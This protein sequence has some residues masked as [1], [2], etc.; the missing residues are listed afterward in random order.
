LVPSIETESWSELRA[1][2]PPRASVS[3]WAR[4]PPPTVLLAILLVVL[5]LL[6]ALARQLDSSGEERFGGRSA[7]RPR[8]SR[9][10]SDGRDPW[11]RWDWPLPQPM[12]H[13]TP[14]PGPFPPPTA[15]A[16]DGAVRDAALDASAPRSFSPRALRVPALVDPSLLPRPAPERRVVAGAITAA[17]PPGCGACRPPSEPL[18]LYGADSR[19][20]CGR[21]AR[22][23]YPA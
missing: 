6:C 15:P 2:M 9:G 4:S 7:C 3:S 21:P 11:A 17:V 19:F 1:D 23:A 14:P 8:S 10:A 22:P 20:A 16:H 18:C 13:R 5:L 12:L